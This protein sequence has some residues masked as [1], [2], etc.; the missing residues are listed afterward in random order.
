MTDIYDE[1]SRTELLE[2]ESLLGR[3][4]ADIQAREALHQITGSPPDCRDCGEPIPGD[5]KEAVPSCTR[6][7]ACER[8]AA[9]RLKLTR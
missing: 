7:I 5:R 8:E 6:C 3:L 2:R 4:R 1:A 9:A